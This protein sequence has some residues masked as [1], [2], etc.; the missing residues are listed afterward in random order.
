MTRYGM[1][2]DTVHC[3][4]CDQC[5]V[6]CKMEHNLPDGLW[7]SRARTQGA[8]IGFGEGVPA[9]KY[10]DTLS[11]YWFTLAC[12]HCAEPACVEVCPTG[13]SAKREDGIV[14][15]DWEK[16]IG[17]NSCVAACPYEGVRTLSGDAPEWFLEFATGDAAMPE[18]KP[19]VMEKCT[20]CVERIDRGEKP[21]CIDVCQACARYFGDLDDP[22]S[23]VSK[24]LV[25]REYDQ[26]LADMGTGPNVY[27]LK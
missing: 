26:L 12:Q 27:F 24:V 2:I 16:C 13:A 6:V 9:G 4:G 1:A 23:E 3:V 17:C 10:P 22:E 18:H 20:F 19:N 21:A 14:T 15:V 25:E 5:S 8:V 7:W 11:M